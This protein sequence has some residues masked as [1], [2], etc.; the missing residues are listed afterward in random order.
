MEERKMKKEKRKAIIDT[1]IGALW[2]GVVFLVV[3]DVLM[4]TITMD[5]PKAVAALM[6]MATGAGLVYALYIILAKY[7]VARESDENEEKEP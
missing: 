6:V 3:V 2:M 1:I 7:M 4:I 5:I